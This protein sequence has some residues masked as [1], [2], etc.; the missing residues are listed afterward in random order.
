MTF[1]NLLNDQFT[2]VQYGE[3]ALRFLV[4]CACGIAIGSERS[5]RLKDAGL[6]TH[7]IVCAAAALM[8]IVSKYA[9]ADL[10]NTAGDTLLGTKGADPSRIASQVISGVSFLGAGV[11]FHNGNSVKGLTTAAGLWATA[12]IGLTIGSGMYMLG[13]FATVVIVIIQ[14]LLHKLNLV[15]TVSSTELRFYAK[16]TKDFRHA[17]Q[18]FLDAKNAEIMESKIKMADDGYANFH[19]TLKMTDDLTLEEL[20]EFLESYGEVKSVSCNIIN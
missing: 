17:F 10:I 4:A 12:G 16:N 2:L 8:M 11:I 20:S 14:I 3:F 1:A 7:M 9:F 18:K 15:E 19:I 6:R 5:R 13:I